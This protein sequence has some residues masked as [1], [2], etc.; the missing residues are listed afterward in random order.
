MPR[1][2]E[3]LPH[4]VDQA[5]ARL[6]ANIRTARLR[7]RMTQE[8]LTKAAGIDRRTLARLEK[9]DAG[10]AIG[11]AMAVLWALGLLPTT[12]A[13]A[14]PDKDEHGKILE[15]ARL[16]QRVRHADVAIDNKF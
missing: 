12:Q 5:A 1:V 9:G 14:D 13:L 4:E 3:A 10:V 8:E 7:R 2:K 6:G 16:P 15:Q 11:R